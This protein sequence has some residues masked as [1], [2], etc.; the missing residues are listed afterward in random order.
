MRIFFI[1]YLV[2]FSLACRAAD[3]EENTCLAENAA[4]LVSLQGS[5][6]YTTQSN[7]QWQTA[8]LNQ[9][10]CA[11]SQLQVKAYSRASLVLP[12]GITIRV[13]ENTILS[14]NNIGNHA[15]T[16]LNLVKGFMHFISRTPQK[17]TITTPIANAGPEGTEFAI[18]VDDAAAKLWVYEGG[19][20]FFNT[21]GDM[22]LNP[23]EH[24]E[25][26]RGLA[27]RAKIDLKPNDAVNWAIYYPPLLPENGTV[28]D[29]ALQ[30]AIQNYR[31]GHIDQALSGLDHLTPNQHNNLFFKIRAALRLIN[32]RVLL[33]EQDIRQL[34]DKNP[35]DPNALALSAM[36]ALSKNQ[37][38]LAQALIKKA[39]AANP[40]SV[41]AI[42]AWSYV[43]QAG[44]SLDKALQAAE[45]AVALA[46]QDAILWARKAEIELD[47]GLSTAS[48]ASATQALLLDANL[49]R[50]HTVMGFAHLNRLDL[51]AAMADFQAAVTLDSTSPLARMGLGLTKIR[52]G[53]LESGRQDIEIAA[54]LDPNNSLIRSYLGKA[55]YEEKRNALAGEQFELAKQ[56]D[57][58]D[59]TPYFYDAILKQTTN[60]PIEALDD[61][62]KAIEL[63]N[64]RA[65]Y[66]SK[67]ALDEDVAA[68]E[69]GLGRIYNSL[70]FEDVANRLAAKS[71][72]NDPSN[73]SA[74]RLLSDSYAG[75]PRQE[76]AQSSEYLQAQLLQPVNYNP[77]QPSLAYTDI[78]IIRGIGPA[79]ASFNE[80]NR[81]FERDG[82]RF[83]STG[84]GGSNHTLGDETAL[85]GIEDKLSYSLG[86]MHY[87]TDGF[88]PNN[89]QKANLYNAFA[90]Y[91]VSPQLS[92]QAEYR[93]RETEHGD[94]NL[95]GD[96]T[97]YDST[98]RD[99][100]LQNTYR[101]GMKLSPAQ[102]SDILFSYIHTDRDEYL[103]SDGIHYGTKDDG[104]DFES[105]Y[106]FHNS[107]LNTI[108]G[109]GSYQTV[110]QTSTQTDPTI[111]P[112][113]SECSQITYKTQQN[114]GYF[115][116][117]FKFIDALN[118]TTGLS[119]DNYQDN[120]SSP[121][122]RISELD[123]KFGFLWKINDFLTLRAAGFKTLKSAIIDSQTLQPVQVAGFNQY[124][125]DF[126]GTV[127]WLHGIGMDS[128]PHK[129]IY[130]G[131]EAYTR[132]LSIPFP[133][134]EGTNYKTKEELYRLYFDWKPTEFLALN[135]QFRFENF[136]TDGASGGSFPTFVETAYLPTEIRL[137]SPSG[138]FSTLKGTYVNQKAYQYDQNLDSFLSRFYLV[139]AAVG[140]RFPKQYGLISLEVKN[141]LNTS[142]IY[143]D[144]QYQ[145]NQ[146]HAPDFL[147]TRMVFARLTFNY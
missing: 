48:A 17:L 147:P 19:V 127:A 58:S 64:N 93:N 96:P 126:N 31:L 123:P 91:E 124:F 132:D 144:R 68:R 76:M 36:L 88:R 79:D 122:L 55:Y 25:A 134:S 61:M 141:L 95:Q 128:H 41:V 20:R 37:K 86:Q 52:T 142:F 7:G 80:Y 136:R 65:I 104:N 3:P 103:S 107:F 145:M 24:A 100:I 130:S 10:L 70:N 87:T 12:N 82:V 133:T 78:N 114:F 51:T 50:T 28:S 66:R 118:L 1:L 140:F 72:F 77:I 63:N 53:N 83:T 90:Q 21:A 39:L 143:Q 121:Q 113:C 115:Y 46:P 59:P 11:G 35:Q 119:V 56:R 27:P 16:L 112:S 108:I 101:Y 47:N 99:K 15:P 85:S 135:T 125:D 84:I 117:N 33:A 131:I 71:V 106:I 43:E 57:L 92:V 109:G 34:L 14:L 23:G 69:A 30:T 73:Y 105:Q 2:V 13:D 22:H 110:H 32:G 45:Q 5:L 9:L 6:S 94:I 18:D 26:Q 129:D 139:D 44:F 60:R 62:Q 75:V 4:K 102:N 42:S 49:E 67:L 29:N 111:D 137:F 40:K 116:N 146:Y 89:D 138:I 8:Q 38:T 98:L 97:N 74:H 120:Q 81:L 54:I